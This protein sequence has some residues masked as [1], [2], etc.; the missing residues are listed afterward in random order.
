MNMDDIYCPFCKCLAIY[1]M[2]EMPHYSQD[3]ECRNCKK[4]FHCFVV[5]ETTM[6]TDSKIKDINFQIWKAKH[7]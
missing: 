4:I 1:E 3:L 5:Y 7:E 6:L 2:E